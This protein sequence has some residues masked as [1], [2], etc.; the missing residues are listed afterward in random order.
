MKY[1]LP[2]VPLVVFLSLLAGATGEIVSGPELGKTVPSLPVYVVTGPQAEKT[3]DFVQD[4]QDKPTLFFIVQH[5]YWGRPVARFLKTLDT[6][7]EKQAD[8]AE[9]VAVWFSDDPAPLKEHLPR[10]QMSLNFAKTVL[11]V[12]EG[13]K[14]GPEGWG[15]NDAA[16]VT[17]VYVVKGKVVKNLAFDSIDEA[18]AP[19]VLEA[20]KPK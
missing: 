10:V 2:P 8:G 9:G 5:A 4:R 1:A 15:L 11:G 18:S 20:L 3:V 13:K 6:E 7:L 17:V 16:A 12:Y 19:A 14:I